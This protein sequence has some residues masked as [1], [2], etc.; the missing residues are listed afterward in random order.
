MARNKVGRRTKLTP[1]LADEIAQTIE[2]GNY[3][4]T[5]AS[6]SGIHK[7]TF[8]RWL[9]RGE[10]ASSGLYKDFHDAVRR[11]EALAEARAIRVV[12]DA[13]PK[14]WK[15]AMTYLERKFPE[16]WGRRERHEHSGPGGTPIQVIEVAGGDSDDEG[17]DA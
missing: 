4:E 6:A 7:A 13:M 2:S 10:N 9:E 11:A 1:E 16:R 14:D 17:E 3:A 15:A 5:A 12:Q 8:Y